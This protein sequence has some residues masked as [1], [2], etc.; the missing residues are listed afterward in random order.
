[1]TLNFIGLWR[2]RVQEPK[3][4]GTYALHCLRSKT[5]HTIATP[6]SSFSL[7]VMSSTVVCHAP[8]CVLFTLTVS[9]SWISACTYTDIILK[10]CTN[11]SCYPSSSHLLAPVLILGY[12]FK[13]L[14]SMWIESGSFCWWLMTPIR[15]P[16]FTG[17]L[18]NAVTLSGIWLFTHATSQ[19][20]GD[21]PRVT[22]F[23][24]RLS[25]EALCP[26]EYLSRIRSGT[27]CS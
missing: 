1:M 13:S 5:L 12:W 22:L 20:L 7:P 23:Q 24:Y 16:Y 19:Y 18:P 2:S 8:V 9:Y 21:G 6:P 14:P 17:L 4:R 11:C 25:G 26:Q 27:D 15:L 10:E 3:A